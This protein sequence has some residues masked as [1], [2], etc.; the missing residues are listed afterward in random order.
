MSPSKIVR[1]SFLVFFLLAGI[2]KKFTKLRC[3]LDKNG[4]ENF[5]KRLNTAKN[6]KFWFDF[7]NDYQKPLH[8]ASQR[9]E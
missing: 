3:Q 4:R 6:R 5:L 2:T 7:F 8:L 1:V 9:A